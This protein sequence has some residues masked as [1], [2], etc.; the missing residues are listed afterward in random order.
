MW[1]FLSGEC[2]S[3]LV[4]YLGPRAQG[5]RLV[6]R[7]LGAVVAEASQLRGVEA[8]FDVRALCFTVCVK[9]SIDTLTGCGRSAVTWRSRLNRTS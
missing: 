1:C 6:S 3:V 8:V 2:P 7:E 9:V 5:G 4:P